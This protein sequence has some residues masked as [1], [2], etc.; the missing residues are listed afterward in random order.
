MPVNRFAQRTRNEGTDAEIL[1]LKRRSRRLQNSQQ[2]KDAQ[3]VTMA[4][5]LAT[6]QQALAAMQA[7]LSTAEGL[8]SGL[9]DRLTLEESLT[10]SDAIRLQAIEVNYL[11]R[12]LLPDW[13]VEISRGLAALQPGNRNYTLTLA[14]ALGVKAGDPI[15]VS[16]KTAVPA[17]YLVGAASAP[18]ANQLQV[19]ISNP[20]VAVGG[21]M[22]IVLWLYTLRP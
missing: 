8:I 6:A 5:Q 12:I 13:S 19:Q 22:T 9:H 20:L 7:T 1:R 21:T 2:N 11:K 15:F 17:G 16:P 3:L 14:A 18:A 4:E 10:A